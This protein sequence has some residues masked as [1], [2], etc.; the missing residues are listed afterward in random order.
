M[1]IRSRI[2]DGEGDGG[3]I[4]IC[5]IVGPNGVGRGCCHRIWR[6]PYCTVAGP[7]GEAG[8]Q[9]GVDGPGGHSTTDVGWVKRGDERVFGVGVSGRGIGNVRCIQTNFKPNL[10]AKGLARNVCPNGVGSVAGS[11]GWRAGDG[12]RAGGQTEAGWEGRRDLA[13]SASNGGRRHHTRIEI[14]VSAVVVAGD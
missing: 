7:K 11:G 13:G 12:A 1:E 3:G 6:T 9:G 10:T 8:R 4:R 5:R 2:V 14:G